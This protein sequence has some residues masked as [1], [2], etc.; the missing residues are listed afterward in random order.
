M[1]KARR[2]YITPH[3]LRL[4]SFRIGLSQTGAV[5]PQKMAGSFKILDLGSRGIELIYMQHKQV[6]DADRPHGS[7]LK[8]CS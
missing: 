8:Q 5:Q 7:G 1:Q 4:E 6:K 3:E 2:F